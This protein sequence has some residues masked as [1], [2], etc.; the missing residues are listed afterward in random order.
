MYVLRVW[1]RVSAEVP[2]S[3]GA[4]RWGIDMSLTRFSVSKR[5]TISCASP[6]SAL[7]LALLS[8]GPSLAESIESALVKAYLGN[9]DINTQR[10]AVRVSDEGVPKARAGYFPTV[11]AS[12]D[13]GLQQSDSIAVG[14]LPGVENS[15]FTKPRGYG[16][17]VQETIF[18]GNRTSNSVK[19]AE[20]SVLAAREQLRYTEQVVLMSGVQYYMDVMRD[21]AIL[22]LDNNNVEVLREQLRQTTDRFNVGEVTKTDVAQSQSAL[23]GAQ[24]TAF[25]AQSTLQASMANFRQVIGVNPTNLAPVRPIVKPLPKT[26]T[27]AIAISLVEHPAITALLHGVDVAALNVKIQEG[28]LYPTVGLTGSVSKRFDVSAL[29]GSQSIT[30]SV[31]GSVNI[32]IWDGGQTYASTREAKERL[33]QQELSSD[34]Q[35][36]KIRASV[37]AAWGA[38]TNSSSIVRA[39]QEQVRA[40]EIAL[41]GIR[42]EAK[43]GQRTTFDVLTAQQ[44]LLDARTKLVTAQHDQV[45]NSFMLLSAVGRL[46]TGTLALNV[47]AYDPRVHFDQ[48]KSKLVGVRTPDGK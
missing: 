19:S 37:V 11:A 34:A 40:A 14:G 27:Q 22:G 41:A 10:A 2:R 9:Q 1:R 33:S 39:A 29:P 28:A 44:T 8:A 13:A 30:A 43:V 35:R 18:N 15:T 48:V 36:E 17:T 5:R 38:N 31:I 25:T 20:S 12:A 24:A 47:R 42:E 46:S 3:L 4:S 45:V 32:P 16:L 21:M 7:V 26:V 6:L 23:A